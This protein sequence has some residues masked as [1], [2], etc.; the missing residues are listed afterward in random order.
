MRWVLAE[1]RALGAQVHAKELREQIAWSGE[2]VDPVASAAWRCHSD[3]VNAMPPLNTKDMAPPQQVPI[4]SLLSGLHRDAASTQLDPEARSSAGILS[5]DDLQRHELLLAIAEAKAPVLVVVS[6][7]LGQWLTEPLTVP[8]DS[9]IRDS[10]V[11]WLSTSRGLEPTGTAVLHVQSLRD[12][13]S[14][15]EQGDA[16][17]MSQWFSIVADAYVDAMSEA[18]RISQSVLAGRTDPGLT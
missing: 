11:R 6:V 8:G 3:V 12:G 16:E 15:Y 2:P 18:L 4:R 5:P 1:C 13:L 14:H 9:L 10:F 17:G 7:L